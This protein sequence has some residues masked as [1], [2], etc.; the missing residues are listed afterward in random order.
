MAAKF[1]VLTMLCF[2]VCAHAQTRPLV[3]Y[4]GLHQG[5]GQALDSLAND[6][7]EQELKRLVAPA[8]IDLTW[9]TNAD[10]T[11]THQEAGRII[12]GDFVGNCS[13]ETLSNAQVA[14]PAKMTLGE[15]SVS[16]GRVLPYFTVDC[17]RVMRT[18]T[19]ML[20]PLSPPMRQTILGRALARVI[21]HE[22]YHI[23]AETTAH[24][25]AGL[26]KAK[27][28]F[29]DL[30]APGVELSPASLQRIRAAYRMGPPAVPVAGLMPPDS[31]QR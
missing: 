31:K 28:T 17:N 30:T 16:D 19:P 24:E 10:R 1:V 29:H 8:G 9:R 26:A 23:L 11:Q 6:S 5:N 27:L 12:V 18:L 3:V 20:Q 7:L 13:V 21:A 25:D 22:I 15:A 14:S 4:P 2:C